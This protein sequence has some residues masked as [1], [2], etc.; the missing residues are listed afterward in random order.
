[1]GANAKAR[2]GRLVFVHDRFVDQPEKG[3]VLDPFGMKFRPTWLI[4]A[5]AYAAFRRFSTS[6]L[7]ID[8][9]SHP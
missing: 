5:S 2:K 1:M 9:N 8:S 3:I 4:E 6:S 7:R